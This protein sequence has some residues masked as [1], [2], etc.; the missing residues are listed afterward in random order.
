MILHILYYISSHGCGH[1]VRA[2]TVCNQFSSD[3]TLTI[4]SLLPKTFFDEELLRQFNYHPGRFDCGCIQSDSITIDIDTTVDTY[5]SIA[6]D[7]KKLLGSEVVWCKEHNVDGIVS[8][9]ASFP[10]EVANKLSIPSIGISNFSWFDIYE[11]YVE[12]RPDFKASV[13]KIQEQYNMA[14]LLLELPPSNPMT[15]FKRKKNVSA[16]ARIGKNIR[17]E[18][19]SFYGIGKEK[20]LALIYTGEFGMDTIAWKKLEQFSEW[21]FIGVYPLSDT[22]ENFHLINKKDFLYQ[23][24]SASADLMITKIGYGTYTECLSNGVPMLYVPRT[25]F[26]EH[27]VLEKAVEDWGHGYCLSRE[28]FY[29]LNWR[30]VLSTVTKN[31]PPEKIKFN[32]AYE[33]ANKIESFFAS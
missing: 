19:Y 25:D 21:E 2:S 11:P 17:N 6:Q 23:D 15:C 14:D 10:F 7:N 20:K 22:P 30:A 31:V 29:S 33:C 27:P 8:D 1:G 16:I 28:D 5:M 3:V 12:K 13:Q 4:R 9:I 26:A 18:I 32:G 24:I